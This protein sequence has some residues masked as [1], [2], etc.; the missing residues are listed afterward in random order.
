MAFKSSTASTISHRSN[1][2]TTHASS[3]STTALSRRMMWFRALIVGYL[4]GYL[5]GFW[6][7]YDTCTRFGMDNTPITSTN[8]YD[9]AYLAAS[10]SRPSW[11]WIRPLLIRPTIRSSWSSS[12]NGG[13]HQPNNNNN[14]NNQN[15]G[16]PL[17]QSIAQQIAYYAQ[18]NDY[19]MISPH[20]DNISSAAAAAAA[21]VSY[22]QTHKWTDIPQP[23]WEPWVQNM[24]K[25]WKIDTN[26]DWC[27]LEE[28]NNPTPWFLDNGKPAQGL[29]Y[30][31]LYK[32]SSSTL[33]GITWSIAT[34]V[35]RRLHTTKPS[36]HNI[37]SS[38]MTSSI[39]Y[40]T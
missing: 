14:N 26:K 6:S 34:N 17:P 13:S 35:A 28:P 29:I 40:V 23:W 20:N 12:K 27:I 37:R 16:P 15:N 36:N 33:E 18:S 4:A 31:K 9:H 39:L 25:P 5:S 1:S 21:T 11:P 19:G 3:S 2:S 7:F 38:N 30:I 32:A 24:T 8:D 10:Q 22:A